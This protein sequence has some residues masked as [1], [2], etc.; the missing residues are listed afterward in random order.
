MDNISKRIKHMLIKRKITQKELAD[1]IQITQATL[2]R[3]LNEINSM[4]A[5]ILCKIATELDVSVDYLLGINTKKPKVKSPF[6][7]PHQNTQE[8]KKVIHIIDNADFDKLN[9]ILGV[10]KAVVGNEVKEEN[11][12]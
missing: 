6:R 8:F 9:V 1:Q 10:L 5:D 3:N 4:R 2:S 7:S 12:I 11:I